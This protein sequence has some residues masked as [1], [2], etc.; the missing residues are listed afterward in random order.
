VSNLQVEYI[1]RDDLIV[2]VQYYCLARNFTLGTW[3]GEGFTYLR[4]KFGKEYPSTEYHWDHGPPYGTVKPLAR[5]L[6]K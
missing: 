6:T 2:G 3:D 1:P 4:R 5:I